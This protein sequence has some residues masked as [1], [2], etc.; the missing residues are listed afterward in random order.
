MLEEM[1][2]NSYALDVLTV[3]FAHSIISG[4]FQ[5]S[6]CSAFHSFIFSK[7]E[8]TETK[9]SKLFINLQFKNTQFRVTTSYFENAGT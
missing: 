8:N 7:K 6:I 3:K 1:I 5:F 4:H 9:G 2:R